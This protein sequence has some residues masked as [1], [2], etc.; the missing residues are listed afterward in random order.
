MTPFIAVLT[1]GVIIVAAL[2]LGVVIGYVVINGILH[3]MRRDHQ[4]VRKTA[5]ATTET[6]G[7]D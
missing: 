1:L 2:G 7:G 4:P 3:A 5:L 6:A